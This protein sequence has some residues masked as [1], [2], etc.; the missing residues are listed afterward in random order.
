MKVV[1]WVEHQAAPSQKFCEEKTSLTQLLD[2]N[3]DRQL[4]LEG[5]GLLSH[6]LVVREITWKFQF[7]GI[8][9]YILQNVAQF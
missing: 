7:C 6:E 1:L 3:L 5:T 8:I 4:F 9:S 2:L